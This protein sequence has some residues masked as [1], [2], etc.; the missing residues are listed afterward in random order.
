MVESQLGLAQWKAS[1]PWLP[2]GLNGLNALNDWN[3]FL[4]LVPDRNAHQIFT[5]FEIVKRVV[6][7]IVA[8]TL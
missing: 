8:I 1:P 7:L 3:M 5:G 2:D 6:D 4:I